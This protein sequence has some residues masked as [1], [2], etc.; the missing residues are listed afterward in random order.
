MAGR[1]LRV[2][3]WS[4]DTIKSVQDAMDEIQ[5]SFAD[6]TGV[7][8]INAVLQQKWS[9]LYDSPIYKN[10]ELQVVSKKFE[11]AI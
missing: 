11:L 8:I 10:P 7:K 9:D 3:E 5:D 6:E 4:S 2:V 1:F